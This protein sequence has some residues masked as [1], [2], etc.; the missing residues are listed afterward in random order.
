MRLVFTFP[1][2]LCFLVLWSD[3]VCSLAGK[4]SYGDLSLELDLFTLDLAQ[5][6]RVLST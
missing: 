3:E 6:N 2:S 1:P 5:Q 4:S